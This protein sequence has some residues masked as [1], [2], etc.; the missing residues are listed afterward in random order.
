MSNARRSALTAAGQAV[1]NPFQVRALIDTGASDTCV[2]PIALQPL[3]LT[4]TGDVSVITP[5]T[6]AIAATRPQYD[7]SLVILHP[8]Q[9]GHF[10]RGTMPIICTELFAA[11]GIHALI[12]RDILQDC[13]FTFDGATGLFSLA[14]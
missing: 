9:M 7:V 2:D 4:P 11:Q 1:P 14:Y 13:L 6:G 8:K 5:S 3:N 10:L 12:G